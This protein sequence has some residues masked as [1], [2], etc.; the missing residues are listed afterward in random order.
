[1]IALPQGPH[2]PADRDLGGAAR[3]REPRAGDALARSVLAGRA[4]FADASAA[5]RGDLRG[6]DARRRDRRVGDLAR[7]RAHRREAAPLSPRGAAPAPRDRPPEGQRRLRSAGP[8]PLNPGSDR[9]MRV[10]TAAEID[11]VLTFPALIEA[12]AEAFRGDIV[13]AGAPSPRDRAAGAHATLLLM[14]AWT[15]AGRRGLRRREDRLGLSRQRRQGLPS[16]IGT[17]LLMDGATGRA[18]RRP[19]RHAPDRLAHGGGL[20]ARRAP[21]RPRRMPA[22]W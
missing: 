2:S 13:D 5:L 1:M 15:G 4:G 21:S 20:G 16:V 7:A 12:L 3:G 9:P 14:P 22:A 6:G 8:P 18:A 19:R 10:V 11:R 17:Y